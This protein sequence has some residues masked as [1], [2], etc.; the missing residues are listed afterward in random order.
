MVVVGGGFGGLSCGFG[1]LSDGFGDFCGGF[2]VVFGRLCLFV[3]FFFP[4]SLG[5]SC[6]GSFF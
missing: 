2:L 5:G 4:L 6:G 1:D 3:F